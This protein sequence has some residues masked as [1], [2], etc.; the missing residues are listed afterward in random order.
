MW[1]IIGILFILSWTW[2]IYEMINAPLISPEQDIEKQTETNKQENEVLVLGYGLLGKELVRQTGWDYI[3]LEE[4]GFDITDTST[5]HMMTKIEFGAI[6][7]CPYKVIVNCIANTNTYSKE[8]DSHWE[9]N[10]SGVDKLVEFCNRWNIKLVH[11]STDYVYANSI[12]NVKE[13]DVPVHQN[14]WYSYTKLLGDSHVQLKSKDYLI[15]RGGHKPNP[16]PFKSAYDNVVG[17]FDYVDKN[18][19]I[20]KKLIEN[21]LSGIYNIGSNTKTMYDLAKETN[22]KVRK[23]TCGK[24]C[25]IPREVVMNINKLKKES[26]K[27]K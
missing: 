17:N 15:V 22:I 3:C 8:R 5:Y 20:I 6:Q 19:Y 11:I 16:F 26:K 10:Y 9:V 12:K 24:S 25:D 14:T 21:N 18:T 1:Y 2:I 27:W 7:Y 4:Q 13:T 23:K